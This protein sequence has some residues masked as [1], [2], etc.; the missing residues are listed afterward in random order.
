MKDSVCKIDGRECVL[1]TELEHFNLQQIMDS[2][3]CFRISRGEFLPRRPDVKN[4]FSVCWKEKHVFIDELVRSGAFLF[5]CTHDDFR[6]VWFDY[7]DLIHD[8]YELV[9][10]K[11]IHKPDPFLSAA[12]EYGNGIRILNQ[13]LF[14]TLVCFM[15]SQNNNIKRIRRSVELMCQKYGK[16]CNNRGF[17][18]YAF[19]TPYRLFGADFKELGL[20]YREEYFQKMFDIDSAESFLCWLERVKH[21]DYEIAKKILMEATGI[22]VKVADC[23]CLFGLRHT[24]AYPI[25]TWM[26][27]LIDRVYGGEFNLVAYQ[28][29]AGYVQQLQFYYFRSN[30]KE[31]VKQFPKLEVI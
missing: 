13:G 31:I 3:Q 8:Y 21:A 27:K 11:L 10:G 20:G 25:D 22:G 17:R 9:A 1:I 26:R 24:N 2:G 29:W 4:T 12:L 14:E 19:P 7:F 30:Q 18:Y 16:P 5:H 15:I 23:I 6:E 28:M